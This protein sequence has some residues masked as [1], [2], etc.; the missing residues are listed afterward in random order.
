LIVLTE[1]MMCNRRETTQGEPRPSHLVQR[2]PSRLDYCWWRPLHIHGR[3]VSHDAI[4]ETG[5]SLDD[6]DINYLSAL[7]TVSEPTTTPFTLQ[8]HTPL[9]TCQHRLISTSCA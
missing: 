7:D 2:S 8:I 4:P 9:F 6:K 1:L 5:C 3:C